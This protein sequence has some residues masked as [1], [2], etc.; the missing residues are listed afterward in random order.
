MFFSGKIIHSFTFGIPRKSHPRFD[1]FTQA[2]MEI[3]QYTQR[4]IAWAVIRTE[5]GISA[6]LDIASI[7]FG[8]F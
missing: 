4:T 5:M 1:R 6:T 7:P 8:K 2:Q 3:L